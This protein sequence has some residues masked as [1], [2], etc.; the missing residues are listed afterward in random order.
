VLD[1]HH[2]TLGLHYLERVARA[3]GDG[4]LAGACA[5]WAQRLV[6]IEGRLRDSAIAEGDDPDR[7]VEPVD[8]SAVGKVAHSVASGIGAAGEWVDTRFSR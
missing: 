4:E 5:D 7:A 3:E 8:T 1:I 2:I 6:E